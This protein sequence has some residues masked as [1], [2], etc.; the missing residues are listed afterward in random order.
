M[1][2]ASRGR[3]EPPESFAPWLGA[4]SGVT[5]SFFLFEIANFYTLASNNLVDVRLVSPHMVEQMLQLG[6][7][8]VGLTLIL[9]VATTAFIRTPQRSTVRHCFFL[10]LML[11][12]LGNVAYEFPLLYEFHL[13]PSA[14]LDEDGPYAT[15]IG[16]AFAFGWGILPYLHPE[17][18]AEEDK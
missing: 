6:I 2:M 8:S 1:R 11:L 15:Y 17:P 18:E 13:G 10:S 5:T 12:T 9:L 16:A 3:V 14:R 7:L 4:I